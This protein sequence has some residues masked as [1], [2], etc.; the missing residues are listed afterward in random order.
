MNE[1]P[2]IEWAEDGQSLLVESQ[3]PRTDAPLGGVVRVYLDGRPSQ[4]VYPYGEGDKP[5]AYCHVYGVWT[6]AYHGS[7]GRR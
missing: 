4:L 3:I 7:R 5:D 6:R 2:R 1:A